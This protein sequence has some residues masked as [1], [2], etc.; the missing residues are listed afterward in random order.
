MLRVLI[1]DDDKDDRQ[2]FCDG[3]HVLNP[4]IEC[5]TAVHGSD[6]LY[7]LHSPDFVKPDIIFLDLNMPRVN[8]VQFLNS[9]KQHSILKVIPVVI[10]TTSKSNSEREHCLS[11]GAQHFITKPSTL[12]D[13][14]NSLKYIL[15]AEHLVY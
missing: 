3:V 8:G 13:F 7:K 12:S 1:I 10:Y 5:V 6:A 2:L 9:I 14:T 4:E 15:T 11:L